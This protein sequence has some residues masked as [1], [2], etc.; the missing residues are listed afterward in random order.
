M[1]HHTPDTP[2][3][4]SRGRSVP[5]AGVLTVALGAGLWG[6]DALFRRG[7]ALSAPSASVVMWEHAVLALILAVPLWRRRRTIAALGPVDWAILLVIGVGASALATIAFTAALAGGDPTTPLLLQ[8][9]Q[10]LIAIGFA[11]VLIGERPGARLAAFAVPAL[12]GAYLVTFADPTSIGATSLRSG[13]L[14]LTAATLWALGTVLG[15]RMSTRLDAIGLTAM[16]ITIGL[17]ATLVA[18]LA[19]ADTPAAPTADQVPAIIGLSLVPG[20]LALV[21]YYRGL[22]RAP[23]SMATLAE[24]AFPLT[25]I[26]VNRI[27]FG[28]TLSTTQWLGTLLLGGSVTALSLV[29]RRG[30]EQAGV[31]VEDEGVLAGVGA[32]DDRGVGPGGDRA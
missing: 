25:A 21:V 7:L 29:G 6:T 14:A 4:P 17:P 10:P 28:T 19:M 16:R 8:K 24:L 31:T 26:L 30:S 11:T 20:L 3:A 23:A 15:R 22:Q 1:S 5:A 9:T 32:L 2:A 18:V 13:A 27:A 12:A